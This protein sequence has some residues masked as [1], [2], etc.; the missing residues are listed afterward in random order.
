MSTFA[1]SKFK[2]LTPI[3]EIEALTPAEH[4]ER[5]KYWENVAAAAPREAAFFRRVERMRKRAEA[6]A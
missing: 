1:K 3:S 2:P 4:R 6:K 5:T